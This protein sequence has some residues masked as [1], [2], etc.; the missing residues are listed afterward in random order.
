MSDVT[1]LMPVTVPPNSAESMSATAK[2]GAGAGKNGGQ[3]GKG[4]KMSP[5]ELAKLK[6]RAEKFGTADQISILA[7]E[8]KK[9]A[10]RLAK[11]KLEKRKAKFGLD[12]PN[13]ANG[14]KK[15]RK[16]KGSK[17]KIAPVVAL[18]PEQQAKV[19][20]RKK[21]FTT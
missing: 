11:E 21:R 12:E 19:E 6:A 5:E 9:E 16:D 1:N 2:T 18:T 13:A 14:N 8:K 7:K 4:L 17:G 10:E 3:K 20:A 15:A